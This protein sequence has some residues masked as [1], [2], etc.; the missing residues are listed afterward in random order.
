MITVVIESA[1]K[2]FASDWIF[3]DLSFRSESGSCTAVTGSNGSGKSTL[4]QL[5]A[6]YLSLNEGTISLIDGA[7]KVKREDWFRHISI[8]TPYLELPEDL[9]PVEV[10]EFQ[11][12]F[13]PFLPGIGPEDF[14]RITQL[15]RSSNKPIRHYSSG[16]KQR[17]KLGLCLL[18]GASLLLLD[19]PVSNLDQEGIQW[20]REL[21]A[22]FR[23]G[24]SVWVCSNAVHD[25]TFYCDQ[26]LQ[27]GSYK[28]NARD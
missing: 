26:N 22:E 23:R 14:L 7:L 9:S 12:V 5:L 17:L 6:G 4:L 19:E 1:G 10:F 21:I 11:Q 25:E 24:R 13:K 3:R 8:A 15:E 27:I 16:M 20:Y 28:P 18:S 2:R